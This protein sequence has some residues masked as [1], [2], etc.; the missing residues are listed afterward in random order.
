MSEFIRAAIAKRLVE[1]RENCA[2]QRLHLRNAHGRR[3]GDTKYWDDLQAKAQVE[4]PKDV[5]AADKALADFIAEHRGFMGGD[6]PGSEHGRLCWEPFCGG[7]PIDQH[8]CQRE[9]G[10]EGIHGDKAFA[11]PRDVTN[12]HEWHKLRES[13]AHGDKVLN[14]VCQVCGERIG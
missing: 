14:G 7:M 5:E 9:E 6:W 10:H 2:V 11:W 12:D 4:R 3:W 8:Y 13:C 1:L